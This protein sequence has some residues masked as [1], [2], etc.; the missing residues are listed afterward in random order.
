MKVEATVGPTV[1]S[2]GSLQS[3]RLDKQGGQVVSELAPRYFEQAYRGNSYLAAN[4][5]AQAVSVALATTYT[6]LVL[7]NPPSS[8]KMGIL[9]TV[10]YSLSV[11]PAAIAPLFLIGQKSGTE[12]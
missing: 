7:S 8:S 3:L 9:K 4:A 11:A 5:G 12:V 6:G 10:S 1:N 2:D